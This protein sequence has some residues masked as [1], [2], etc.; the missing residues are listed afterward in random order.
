MDRAYTFGEILGAL[1]RRAGVAA[2]VAA[3]GFTAAAIFIALMPN[4]YRAGTVVVAEPL[5]PHPDL[6]TPSNTMPLEDRVKTVRQ[7]VLSRAMLSRVLNEFSLFPKLRGSSGDDAAVEELRKRLEVNAEGDGL[8]SIYV[9]LPEKEKA[10]PVANRLA[11]LFIEQNLA[12]RE[13]QAARTTSIIDGSMNELAGRLEKVE[14]QI[15]AFKRAHAS[16][17]PEAIES[18]LREMDRLNKL[19]EVDTTF[20]REAE[21]RKNL[22]GVGEPGHD[23]EVGR[24][25]ANR[26]ALLGKVHALSA[27]FKDDYPDLVEA[28]NEL[29]A[30]E[31]DLGSA[32]ERARRNDLEAQRLSAEIQSDKSSVESARRRMNELDARLG[33]A[34][35]WGAELA[36]LTRQ[37]EELKAKH[38]QLLSK[39][40]EAE[41]SWE[42]EKKERAGAFRVVDAATQPSMPSAPDRSRALLLALVACI[43]L[44]G[45]V[46][47]ALDAHD[48]SLRSASEAAGAVRLPVLAMVP[49]META[50]ADAGR[51]ERVR[52]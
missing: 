29:G 50:K 15:D 1:R 40:V 27:Q 31:R 9:R 19:V 12:V 3:V 44:G 22:I 21:H 39:K 8:F 48:T 16:E 34:P 37:E 26:E 49:R 35:K 10:A 13:A 41:V 23:T 18:N 47:F 43:A 46:G 36:V 42:L 2:L 4:E 25:A 33:A 45:A 38:A 30:L 20:L 24:L 28:R 5:R 7:Q 52:S 51:V 32:R 11:E 17:L 14:G 6:V